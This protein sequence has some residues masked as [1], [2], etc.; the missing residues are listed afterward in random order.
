MIKFFA[1]L[2]GLFLLMM[3]M[4]VGG[5]AIMIGSVFHQFQEI[6]RMV[7][8]KLSS[9]DGE[10]EPRPSRRDAPLRGYQPGTQAAPATNGGMNTVNIVLLVL[11]L[12]GMAGVAWVAA[13]SIGRSG[14]TDD[15]GDAVQVPQPR[16]PA[17]PTVTRATRAAAEP[18]PG[19]APRGL[20]P[21][22]GAAKGF[23]RR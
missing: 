4:M 2:A 13:G 18:P 20:A 12:G 22:G 17:A 15:D 19:I 3:L 7:E 8:R 21:V 23:G 14:A 1:A 5:S 6:D 9:D 16:T 11:G 10:S